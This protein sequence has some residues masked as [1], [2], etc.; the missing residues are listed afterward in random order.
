MAATMQRDRYPDHIDLVRESVASPG[1]SR[2]N[3]ARPPRPAAVYHRH[4]GAARCRSARKRNGGRLSLR[5]RFV[6]VGRRAVSGV[7][8]PA[9]RRRRSDHCPA[10]GGFW[11]ENFSGPK[12]GIERGTSIDRRKSAARFRIVGEAVSFLQKL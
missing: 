10:R 8:P 4:S 12:L 11:W 6:A 1:K 7:A 9:S 2:A 3:A 5:Y